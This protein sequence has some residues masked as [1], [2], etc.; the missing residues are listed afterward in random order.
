[1]TLL[2]PSISVV[3]VVIVVV[4]VAVFSL[5]AVSVGAVA[6]FSLFMTGSVTVSVINTSSGLS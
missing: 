5:V 3:F 2:V 6:G 4:L 1:M